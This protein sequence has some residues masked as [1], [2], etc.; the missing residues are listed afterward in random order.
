MP[1]PLKK[2]GHK[3]MGGRKKGAKNKK[4]IAK[5]EALGKYQQTMLKMM[6]STMAAQ[7]QSAHGV[8]V[9]LRPRLVKNQKTHKL[10]RSG[11]LTQVKDPEEII[12]LL[13]ADERGELNQGEDF[14]IIFA[15][16]PNAKAIDDIWSRLW[17]KPKEQVDVS[18]KA[19]ELKKVQDEMKK[20]VAIGKKQLKLQMKQN[21]N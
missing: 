6:N 5:E 14:H 15:K 1:S 20:L 21:E 18:F 19:D 9:C 13:E 3:K 4:T 12:G 17:G 7:L 8:F 2:K 16:D 11:E 10:E